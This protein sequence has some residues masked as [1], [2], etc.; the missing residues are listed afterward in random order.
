MAEETRILS[1]RPCR[2]SRSLL[3]AVKSYDMRPSRVT[4]H[5]RGRCAR[6]FIALKNPSPWP[7]SNPHAL[8]PV[9]STLTTT[10]PKA[11]RKFLSNSFPEWYSWLPPSPRSCDLPP[12]D[13]LVWNI[14]KNKVFSQRPTDLRMIIE[15]Q[16]ENMDGDKN[17]CTTIVNCIA[18]RCQWCIEQN[19][20]HFEQFLYYNT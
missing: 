9:A 13:F 4:S 16:F 20:I 1:L 7:D 3:H 15:A 11:T 19:G 10:P 14:M 2:T 6:I 18:E 5:S 17:V 8:G 12:C